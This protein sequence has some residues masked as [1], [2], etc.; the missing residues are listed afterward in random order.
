MGSTRHGLS[1]R[2]AAETRDGMR[3]YR[4]ASPIT[5]TC[6]GGL[7]ILALVASQV[8]QSQIVHVS[9]SSSGIA[10]T[11][12]GFV[13][14]LAFTAVGVAVARREP[15]NPM[16]WLLLAVVL[17]V[18]AGTVGPTYARLDYSVHHG[19]LPFGRVAVLL[20]GAW[21]YS[22]ILVPL[23]ILL[24]PD[25][26]LGRRWRWPLRAYATFGVLVV[27]GTL[28]VAVAAFSLRVP[29][30]G[31]GNLVGLSHPSGAN[32]W[33]GPVQTL[34]LGAGFLLAI[35][36]ILYQ[37]LRYRRASREQRQQLKCLAVGAAVLLF[38]FVVNSATG[39]GSGF[40]GDVTFSVGLAALPLAMGVGILKYRLYEIDRLLS[41]TISYAIVTALLIGTFIGLVALTTNTLALS[42]RV[43][44]AASTLA[45]A[46]L[47]NPLRARVQKLVDRRFNRA[48]YDAEAI[49]TAFTMRLRDA[50]DLDTVRRELL[51]AV[52]GAVQPTHASV[53]IRPRSRA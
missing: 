35:T 24:F 20:S 1:D 10:E 21:E 8:L 32:A 46:A 3:C 17:A 15:R 52:D 53:W 48:R 47:F 25:G 44:V 39:G 13:F 49:V 18:D 45:A 5:A 40:V 43:G 19:T 34:G 14:V 28:S 29:V 2:L 37:V 36:S 6:L 27:A 51:V 42:G 16:G 30:D 50:V 31:S 4:V 22:F 9:G 41:R 26:R 11:A 38:C 33:F 7:S 12:A 23:V